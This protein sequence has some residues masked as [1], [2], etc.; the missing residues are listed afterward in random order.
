[1]RK[2]G[3]RDVGPKAAFGGQ[4]GGFRDETMPETFAPRM[5]PEDYALQP[6]MIHDLHGLL[7]WIQRQS[8]SI[9]AARRGSNVL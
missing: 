3:A 6:Q 2:Y 7:H 9:T 4:D 1:M 5:S 8:K